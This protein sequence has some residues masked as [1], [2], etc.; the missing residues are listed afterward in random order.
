MNA[1]IKKP[2]GKVKDRLNNPSSFDHV[3]TRFGLKYDYVNLEMKYRAE[4]GFGATIT[5]YILAKVSLTNCDKIL[6]IQGQ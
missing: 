5:T 3:E 4:N 1:Y 6:E 2:K